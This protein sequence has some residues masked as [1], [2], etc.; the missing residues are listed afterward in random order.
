MK[1]ENG[2]VTSFDEG[3][4]QVNIDIRGDPEIV[5]MV[6]EKLREFFKTSPDAKEL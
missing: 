3:Y 4:W 6:K 1:F 2:D 5:D